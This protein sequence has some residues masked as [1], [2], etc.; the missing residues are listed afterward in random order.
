MKR[1]T[2]RQVLL[3]HEQLLHEFGGTLASVTKGC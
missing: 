2:K 1:L 3:L